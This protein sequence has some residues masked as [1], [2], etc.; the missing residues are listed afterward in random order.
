MLNNEQKST[1]FF[2]IETDYVSPITGYSLK[3]GDIISDGFRMQFF[4]ETSLSYFSF[5]GGCVT[6]C[7]IN[8]EF[9]NNLRRPGVYPEILAF[10][11][12]L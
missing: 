9:T 6:A 4:P 11:E 5:I 12:Y 7:P 3:K 8:M 1:F 2:R 10:K